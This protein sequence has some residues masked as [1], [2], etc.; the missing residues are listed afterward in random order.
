[1]FLL[2]INQKSRKKEQYHYCNRKKTYYKIH[3]HKE[4]GCNSRQNWSWNEFVIHLQEGFIQYK[5]IE[6]CYYEDSSN[7]KRW[8]S[9]EIKSPVS[10][11][12]I[13]CI[14]EGTNLSNIIV[15]LYK[16]ILI[17]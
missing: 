8:V 17:K 11:E 12:N 6:V 7:Q 5:S 2:T 3:L 1:M 13:T 4:Y 14:V 16:Y 10:K 15:E 9:I